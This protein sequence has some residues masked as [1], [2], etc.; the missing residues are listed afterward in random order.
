MVV[1]RPALYKESLMKEVLG[2]LGMLLFIVFVG[3]PLI[4]GCTSS[5]MGQDFGM[6]FIIVSALVMLAVAGII[7]DFIA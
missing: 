1:D 4:G 7:K 3:I 5:L 6:G 2:C